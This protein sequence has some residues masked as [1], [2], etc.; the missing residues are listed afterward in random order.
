MMKQPTD[1]PDRALGG[2][3]GGAGV[4]MGNTGVAVQGP[5]VTLKPIPLTP[6]ELQ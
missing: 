4:L 5:E 1:S 6:L 3:A 2:Q